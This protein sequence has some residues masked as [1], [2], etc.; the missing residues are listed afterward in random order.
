MRFAILSLFL[1]SSLSAQEPA[2]AA[3]QNSLGVLERDLQAIRQTFP[4]EM[5][6]YMKN[7]RTGDEIAIDSDTVYETFSVIKIPIMAEVLRQAETGKFK[8]SDRVMLKASD[9]R[10]PSGVLYTLEPGLQPTIKDLI[11]LMIII[12]DNAATDLLGDKVGRANVTRFMKELGLA[13][14]QIEFS[15]LDW[16]RKWLS[17]LDASYQYASGDKTLAFPFGRYSDEQVSDAFRKTIYESGIYFGHSTTREI[18]KLLEMIVN[19]KVVSKKASDFMLDAMKKQQVNNRFPKYLENVTIAH[20]TGDGQPTIGND[21]GV[22]W[23]KDQPIVLV[24]FTG[25]HRGDTESLHDAV[26]R[27][28]ALVGRHYGAKLDPRFSLA[29]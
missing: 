17:R 4:G 2:P 19:G 13:K 21:A 11:T 3:S 9:G 28:A 12:S 8:L 6:I 10:L 1:V 15:D 27:A 29:P 16:D 14:T 5:S 18:G 7:V 20:K 22:L 26:A 25:H 24:V 23:V